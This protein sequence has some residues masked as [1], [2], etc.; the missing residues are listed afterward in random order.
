MGEKPGDALR[1]K[2]TMI[3]L[4]GQYKV[5]CNNE[6]KIKRTDVVTFIQ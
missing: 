1:L 3:S 2:S 6:N 4:S 5:Q